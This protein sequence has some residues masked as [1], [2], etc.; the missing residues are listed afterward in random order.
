MVLLPIGVFLTYKAMND[1][2]ILNM[3][4]YTNIIKRF[5]FIRENRKYPVKSVIIE[6][7]QY[8]EIALSLERLTKDVDCFLENQTQLTYR[9]YWAD[10]TYDKD[11]F[12]IKTDMEIVLNKISN[13]RIAKVLSKA[14]EYPVLISNART[15]KAGTK[16]ALI[17]M[18]F[19]P[20]GIILRLLSIPFELRI[21]KDLKTV[22]RLNSELITIANS[23]NDN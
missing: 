21:K 16:L 3:D 19:F 20:I 5:L 10:E 1:S 9:K 13:S 18:Y 6:Q 11:L 15:F 8:N 12:S 4:T 23:I 22:K 2:V 14:E 17:S 7:P